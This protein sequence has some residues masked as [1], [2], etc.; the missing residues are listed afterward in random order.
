MRPRLY[1]G[2]IFRRQFFALFCTAVVFFGAASLAIILGIGNAIIARQLELTT[3]YREELRSRIVDWL[4]ERVDDVQYFARSLE[5]VGPEVLAPS[6][7][8]A[9]LSLF[10][11][12][13]TV[14]DDAL[15][16]DP[17][18]RVIAT[19]ES[20][21]DRN[22]SIADRDYFKA[23]ASGKVFVSGF[24]RGRESGAAEIA[25]AAPI[26]VGARGPSVVVGFLHLEAIV[27]LVDEVRLGNQG[28]AYLVDG[29]GHPI[30]SEFLRRYKQLGADAVGAPLDNFA[31]EALKSG[32]EGSAQYSGYDGSPVL[33][34]YARLEPL[35]LGLVVELSR[36]QALRPISSMLA[37][38][39][40]F[41]LVMMAVIVVVAAFL[42]LRLVAP[43]RALVDAVDGVI[44]EKEFEP[45]DIRTGT[46]LDQLV[47]FFNRMVSAVRERE[48]QLKDNAARDSLTGLYNHARI[49]EF[50]DLEIRRKRRTE[51]KVAFVMLD[52]DYFKKVND[53]FGHLAGDEA[54]RG[55]ARILED[56]VRGGDIAGRYGGE[57]FS[58][59]LD[60]RDDE[61]VRTFCERI[62]KSVEESAFVSEDELVRV[63]VSLGWVRMVAEG[64]GPYEF[65]RNAD[66][67]LYHAKEAGRNRVVGYGGTEK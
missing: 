49:E 32:R 57:E 24:I 53:D 39:L 47:E 16:A 46:E 26:R 65:V 63:T 41:F 23:A 55:I 61:E 13:E 7:A 11:T 60:A 52:I 17:D 6:R 62:R 25:V 9:R 44:R 3:A 4:S 50:L 37:S 35:D 20:L 40:L 42:S 45:L 19:R 27:A 59:I 67:A 51:G 29:E 30:S 33:G 12:V 18:G 34:S 48:K 1:S 14:F 56:S 66:R 28:A 10:L 54:L 15:I 8:L 2:G 31:V 43:I 58:V 22:V 21:A 5:F 36:S 38:G 64:Y